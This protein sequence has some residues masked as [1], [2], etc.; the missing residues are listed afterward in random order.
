MRL[1]LLRPPLLRLFSEVLMHAGERTYQLLIR[2]TT[3]QR[4]RIGRLGEFDFPAGRYVYTGSAKRCLEARIAYHLSTTKALRWHVDF[5]LA[6]EAAQVFEV[7]RFGEEECEVNQRTSGQILIPG[8]GASDCR[9]GC[10]S[11]L[12]YCGDEQRA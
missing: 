9:A 10:V 6:A 2:L 1:P 4:L 11:H 12:K 7:R 5:L 8:F 3:P